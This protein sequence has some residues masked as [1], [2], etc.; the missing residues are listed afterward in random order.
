MAWKAIITDWD[1]DGPG[2]TVGYY[3][4][5]DPANTPDPSEFLYS[6]VFARADFS[7]LA[8]LQAQVIAVGQSKRQAYNRIQ[9][10]KNTG[11]ITIT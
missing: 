7:T 5:A 8:D 10:M 6:R 4:D 11:P 1:L 3:D 2:V 9:Q